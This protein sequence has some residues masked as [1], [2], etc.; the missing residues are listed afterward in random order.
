MLREARWNC[1]CICLCA[2]V[3]CRNYQVID[4]DEGTLENVVDLGVSQ[5]RHKFGVEFF[6]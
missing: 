2:C 4:G 5:V 3:G 1:R 6:C